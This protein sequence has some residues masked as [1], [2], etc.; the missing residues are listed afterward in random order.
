MCF[1]G[2]SPT[3]PLDETI[4][5]LLGEKEK[6][7]ALLPWLELLCLNME[8]HVSYFYQLLLLLQLLLATFTNFY[9]GGT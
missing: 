9:K 4:D 2:A 3:S 7:S 8:S 5:I 6:K 1:R